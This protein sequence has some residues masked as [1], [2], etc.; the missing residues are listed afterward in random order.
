MNFKII[1]VMTLMTYGFNSFAASSAYPVGPVYI[2]NKFHMIW[3]WRDTKFANT[4]Y[5]LS[6]ATSE[7]FL[8]WDGCKTESIN[9]PL[10]NNRDFTVDYGLKNKNGNK[11]YQGLL[12]SRQELSVVDGNIII[13]YTKN[14]NN[15]TQIVN[16]IKDGCNW[17]KKT[18]TK[19]CEYLNLN[20][21]GTIEDV[22]RLKFGKVKRNNN[23]YFQ[24][25]HN[26]LNSCSEINKDGFVQYDNNFNIINIVNLKN[27]NNEKNYI[28][29]E[30]QT[31]ILTVLKTKNTKDY[32]FTWA[33]KSNNGDKRPAC[34]SFLQCNEKDYI[35][36]IFV[37]GK[38][39]SIPKPIKDESG[40]DL[41]VWGG[42][43]ASFAVLQKENFVYL[44]Y[45]NKNKY[46]T[47]S[48]ISGNR[49][50]STVIVEPANDLWDS[51]NNLELALHE[52]KLWLTGNLHND[53]LKIFVVDEKTIKLQNTIIENESVSYTYPKFITVGDKL[54]LT[55]RDGESGNGVYKIFNLSQANI[56]ESW[57]L[58]SA[59]AG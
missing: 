14:D 27:N 13:T 24:R 54:L 33:T 4:T 16:A 57:N 15:G 40:S 3:M 34:L 18:I 22:Q 7:N 39:F 55:T 59:D 46:V 8:N 52:D 26:E 29:S 23:G 6:Y 50:I 31:N 37:S 2:N 1:L 53:P 51:H 17:I 21:L 48:K 10:Y 11:E 32:Y 12:N 25:V 43:Q 41:N 28:K 56:V 19:N 42:S 45:F 20:K 47:L 9:V 58:F 44:A 35:S 38:R 5:N 36:K 49:V 30:L